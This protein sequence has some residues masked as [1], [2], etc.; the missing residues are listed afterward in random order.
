MPI[1]EYVC[2]RCGLK[3]ELHRSFW[4]SDADI[5]CPACGQLAPE[6]QFSSFNSSNA[7]SCGSTSSSY[8]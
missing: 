2:T 5:K 1:Y 8:G 7:N 4:Q 3:F 6:R